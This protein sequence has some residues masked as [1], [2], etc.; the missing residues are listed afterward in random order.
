MQAS[1]EGSSPKGEGDGRAP[2]QTIEWYTSPFQFPLLFLEEF[3]P[4][5]K[6]GEL[7]RNSV[8]PAPVVCGAE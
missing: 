4:V 2:L 6:Y 3:F 8:G 7:C 5:R 1:H